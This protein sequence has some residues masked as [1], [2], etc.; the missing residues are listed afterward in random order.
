MG[1]ILT[2]LKKVKLNM[3]RAAVNKEHV[4]LIIVELSKLNDLKEIELVLDNNIALDDDFSRTIVDVIENNLK[5]KNLYIS[6]T[7]KSSK[8]T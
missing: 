8:I 5:V 6:L 2:K 3:S 1:Q 4:Y 7:G